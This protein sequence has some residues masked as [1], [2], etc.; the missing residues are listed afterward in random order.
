MRTNVPEAFSRQ[1][2]NYRLKLDICST[3]PCRILQPELLCE[4][5][6]NHTTKPKLI[7]HLQRPFCKCPQTVV[8][9]LKAVY[10]LFQKDGR[11][12]KCRWDCFLQSMHWAQHT[13]GSCCH[14][15]PSKPHFGTSAGEY[16]Q[17]FSSRR[18]WL[19][20]EHQK[21]LLLSLCLQVK[22][23]KSITATKLLVK[24]LSGALVKYLQLLAL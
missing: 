8:F 20:S 12:E 5:E 23:N 16:M 22:E 6:N 11:V 10:K 13:N 18:N 3:N 15:H 1:H 9:I 14:S 7:Y 17:F 24:H 2:A 19:C 21:A 4:E